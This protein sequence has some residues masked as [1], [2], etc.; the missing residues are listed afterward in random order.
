MAYTSP[1]S[2]QRPFIL[3][4]IIICCFISIRSSIWQRIFRTAGLIAYEYIV[5]FIFHSS[6]WLCLAKLHPSP[7]TTSSSAKN[8]WAF[9]QVFNSRIDIVYLPPFDGKNP[10]YVPSRSKLFFSRLWDLIW[11]VGVIYVLDTFHLNIQPEDFMIEETGFLDRIFAITPREAIIRVYMVIHGYGLA[12]CALRAAH[13]AATC[14]ALAYGDSPQRWR[15]LFGSITDA[16]T[17]RRWYSYV[18]FLAF[19]RFYNLICF[20]DTSG[21]TSC[22]KHSPHM[23]A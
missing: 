19:A 23:L 10:R 3:A 13:S 20:L 15:P 21:I 18:H 2:K 8:W 16:T 14:V 17:V 5:G 22:A 11:L 4:L 1:S 7:S 12:Y 6:Y 9:N